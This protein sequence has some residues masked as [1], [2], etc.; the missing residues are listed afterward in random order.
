MLNGFL[1]IHGHVALQIC[2]I[3]KNINQHYNVDILV[4]AAGKGA[5]KTT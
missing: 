4:S 1:N 3:R 5:N 2:S